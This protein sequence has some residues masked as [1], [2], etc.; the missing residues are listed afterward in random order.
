MLSLVFLESSM[1]PYVLVVHSFSLLLGAHLWM[2]LILFTHSTFDEHSDGFY[3]WAIMN[4]I[5]V[6]ID[7]N[8]YVNF[9]VFISLA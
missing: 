3:F 8:L 5:V 4:T 1:P 6:N 9:C 7:K 2:F